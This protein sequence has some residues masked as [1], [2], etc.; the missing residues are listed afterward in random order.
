MAEM[1]NNDVEILDEDETITLYDEKGNPVEFY[2]VACVEY[3][4]EFYA[5]MCPKEPM[6][7][8]A[9]DEALIFKVKEVDEEDVS[10]EQVMDEDVLQAVFNEYL[11]ALPDDCD[12][13]HDCDCDG[14]CDCEHEHDHDCGCGCGHKHD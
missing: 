6:E 7:D 5:L 1:N 8:L 4:G 2:E 13:D 12:C 3:Q 9:D 10:F 14:E 11:N